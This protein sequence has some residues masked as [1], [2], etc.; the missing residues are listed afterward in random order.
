LTLARL[1]AWLRGELEA[2]GEGAATLLSVVPATLPPHAA[3]LVLDGRIDRVDAAVADPSHMAVL[4]FK[5]GDLH[6]RRDV[7]H[8]EELQVTLY[9]AAVAAGAV[10]VPG[11]DGPVALGDRI[12][13]GAYYALGG[14]KSGVGPRLDLPDLAGPGRALLLDGAARL[15]RLACEAAAPVGPF[16]L[17]PRAQGGERLSRLPCDRCD[18]R[19]VCRLEEADLPA[20]AR[21]RVETL[22]NQRED[23]W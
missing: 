8:G 21:R 11:A 23:A 18:W 12:V 4:D 1:H 13:E 20:P 3:G 14:G 6:A 17:I 5:T 15:V 2:L 7:E 22:V 10:A 9:A 19:G 16:P